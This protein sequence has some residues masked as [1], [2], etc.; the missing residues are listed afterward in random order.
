MEE[1]K[2][3]EKE[4]SA[5]KLPLWKAV[6]P[7]IVLIIALMFNVRKVFGDASLDGSNQFILLTIAA[8][9][10]LI[11]F[12]ESISF[13]SIVTSIKDQIGSVS[14]AIIILLLVGALSGSWLVSGIIPTMI[15]YGL[16]ILNPSYFLLAC[17]VIASIVSVVTGSS[18]TTSATV[19]IALIGI[20]KALEIPLGMTAGAIL[21]GAYFGDKLS[22][23]SDTTNLASGLAGVDLFTHIKY[24]LKTTIPSI[25]V[26]LV[27][28]FIAGF[29]LEPTDVSSKSDIATSITEVFTITPFVLLV[30]L[31]VFIL[32]L[33][34][35][36]ALVS[37]FIG[38]LA[39]GIAALI[40]QQEALL[41]ILNENTLNFKGAYKALMVAFTEKVTLQTSNEILSDLLE[42]KGMSGMLNT[43][44]LIICAMVLGGSLKAIGALDAISQAILKLVKNASG[45]IASVVGVTF[46]TNLTAS[47]QYLAIVIPSK[48]F[49]KSFEDKGLAP[50]N[51]SRTIEDSGTVTSVL[52]PYNTCGAYHADT[53]GVSVSDFAMFA[54]FNWVSPLMSLIY[55]IFNIKIRKI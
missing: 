31:L 41:Q 24:M 43:I 6:I 51:L 26:T 13:T 15:Y 27:F 34:K 48:M 28:F 20:A 53:L 36:P 30:P 47:D 33:K 39:G 42:S 29:N 2:S 3:L 38:V 25:G 1:I 52:I 16:H 44:W 9:T 49:K 4:Q 35:V 21:S 14:E 12:T 23:L 55:G 5:Y 7:I 17:V 54:V 11:G 18:W 50:E 32:I 8:I 22:P 45:L 10:V 19:G 46:L 40:F 37:L